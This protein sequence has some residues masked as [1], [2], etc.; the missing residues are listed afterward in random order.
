MKLHYPPAQSDIQSI[1]NDR[2]L[3][4]MR[5]FDLVYHPFIAATPRFD[6]P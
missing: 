4:D 1:A 5:M 6:K 3:N 2:K